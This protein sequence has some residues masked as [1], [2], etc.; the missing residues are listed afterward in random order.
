MSPGVPERYRPVDALSCAAAYVD[1]EGAILAGNAAF[2]ALI[3][4]SGADDEAGAGA[5]LLPM[6]FVQ[7]DRQGVRDLLAA[8]PNLA[9][10]TS[11]AATLARALVPT[12]AEF[13]PIRRKPRA[14][15]VWL[16]TLRPSSQQARAPSA[17]LASRAAVTAGIV[18]DLRAPVQ[19]VLGWASLLK[20]KHD[21]PARIEHALTIIERN[22][23]LLLDLLEDLLEQTR[24]SW[25]SALR[26]QKVDL[27]ELVRDE[28]RAVQPLADEA[29]VTVSLEIEWTTV[30]VE[31]S[32]LHLRRVVANLVGNALKFTPQGGTV[33]CRV[34]RA[35]ALAGIVVRD[36]GRG[37]GRESLA[38]IFEPFEQEPESPMLRAAGLGLGLHVVRQLVESHGGAVA[39]AS[40]GSG[41]GATF[42]VLL[43][44]IPDSTAVGNHHGLCSAS[45]RVG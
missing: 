42:T 18:H 33:E 5:V 24:P 38:R 23:E 11:R 44:A 2:H 13:V 12:L 20:R 30:A 6:L 16:V 32:E 26:R 28:V 9:R 1:S 40:P 35:A 25:T 37:I 10:S 4:M 39:A 7:R 21:E 45:D 27:V 36:N 43:P 41:R 19:V 17:D 3:S 34:W 15:A 22:A 29:G 8:P 14:G 31:G